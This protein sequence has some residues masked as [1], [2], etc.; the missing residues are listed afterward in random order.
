MDNIH[1]MDCDNTYRYLVEKF[2]E[3]KIV[4]RYEWLYGVLQEYI[5]IKKLE[6]EVLIS[7]DILNHVIVDYF[8]DIDRLKC[9]QNISKTHDSKIY[10]YL[11]FWLLRH[12]PLQLTKVENAESNAFI[13]EEFVCQLIRSYLFAEPICPIMNN[14]KETVDNFV[15]TLLYYFKYREYSAKNIELI[16]L[17]FQAGRGYQ[18]SA[19]DQ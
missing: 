6:G 1:K 8:V 11:A 15:E 10:A 9:F 19:D 17:A 7:T 3:E 12:K 5:R 13:N 18:Y 14:Q 16:I 2:G 4:S